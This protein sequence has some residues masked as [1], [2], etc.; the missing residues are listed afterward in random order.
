MECIKLTFDEYIETLDAMP[1][2]EKSD[3]GG[4][5]DVYN[6]Q[7]PK[8]GDVVIACAMGENAVLILNRQPSGWDNMF[9]KFGVGHFGFSAMRERTR[10]DAVLDAMVA[11]IDSATK[12]KSILA[13]AKSLMSEEPRI[14]LTENA[15][16][17]RINR[18][19]AR[20][21]QRLCKTRGI[22]NCNELGEFYTVD[23]YKFVIDTHVDPVVWGREM[24][25]IDEYEVVTG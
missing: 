14:P 1:D 3:I 22:R 10:V 17:K 12:A 19:L 24:G 8:L 5:M 15:V 16:L 11:E 23:A 4:G 18:V 21:N 2:A 6:G 20:D 9:K 25:V 7:H 13:D